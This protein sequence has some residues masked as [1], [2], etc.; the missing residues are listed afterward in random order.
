MS[1]FQEQLDSSG[2]MASVVA[3]KTV[4]E[5]VLGLPCSFVSSTLPASPWL[6]QFFTFSVT[7]VDV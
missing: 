5:Q 7:L 6:S 1:A 4:F 2:K 3:V